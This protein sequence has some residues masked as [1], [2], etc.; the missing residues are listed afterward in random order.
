MDL[1]F[2]DFNQFHRWLGG[3]RADLSC[4]ATLVVRLDVGASSAH[5]QTLVVTKKTD[6][7]RAGITT[8]PIA[9]VSVLTN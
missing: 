8:E 1:S 6:Y 3:M 9:T 7:D 2:E 5:V 4:W